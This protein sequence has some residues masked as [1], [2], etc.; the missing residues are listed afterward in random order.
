MKWN[1]MWKSIVN[2]DWFNYTYTDTHTHTDVV[3]W[4]CWLTRNCEMS[5]NKYKFSM[6]S[7]VVQRKRIEFFSRFFLFIKSRNRTG[8]REY[9]CCSAFPITTATMT[10]FM[11]IRYTEFILINCCEKKIALKKKRKKQFDPIWSSS[12]SSWSYDRMLISSIQPK[13]NK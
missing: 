6:E 2:S 4:N 12:S 7:L 5:I 13:I 10:M 11:A 8:K 1:E 9:S 3:I